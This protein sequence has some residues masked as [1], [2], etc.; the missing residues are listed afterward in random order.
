MKLW[1][2]KN[3]KLNTAGDNLKI[4]S[5]LENLNNL[6]TTSPRSK[7]QEKKTETLMQVLYRCCCLHFCLAM[8][9]QAPKP[10]LSRGA[11]LQIAEIDATT[12]G[13]STA[14]APTAQKSLIA[15]WIPL[16]L[17]LPT[18]ELQVRIKNLDHAAGGKNHP[19]TWIIINSFSELAKGQRA[20][21]AAAAV[22]RSAGLYSLFEARRLEFDI[23]TCVKTDW[24]TAGREFQ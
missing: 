9:T 17:Q 21:V 24:R 16:L 4:W 1:L 18:P 12:T 15:L 6:T 22:S 19:N 20:R 5:V 10:I 3:F 13:H 11:R 23:N 14:L 2:S 8:S 7:S